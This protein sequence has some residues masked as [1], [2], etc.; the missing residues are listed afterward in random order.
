VAIVYRWACSLAEGNLH[1]RRTLH[2]GGF[3]R[4]VSVFWAGARRSMPFIG[5]PCCGVLLFR[6]AGSKSVRK[7]RD[8]LNSAGMRCYTRRLQAINGELFDDNSR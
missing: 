2:R 4:R 1:L 3:S 7:T 6:F 5:I 8:A